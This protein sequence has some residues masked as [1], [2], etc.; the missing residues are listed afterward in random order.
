MKAK[1]LLLLLGGV[2]S[3]D[4]H[5]CGSGYGYGDSEC[6]RCLI[7][8]V[9]SALAVDRDACGLSLNIG[10]DEAVLL[11]E[12]IADDF[13]FDANVDSEAVLC[14][15]G[16]KVNE[17]V[18]ALLE[19]AGGMKVVVEQCVARRLATAVVDDVEAIGAVVA[20]IFH[21]SGGPRQECSGTHKER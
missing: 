3:V 13:T 21:V 6:G 4:Y 5:R 2:L 1:S 19:S 15:C 7:E 18:L 16:C 10:H 17:P 8:C 20:H 9:S 14:R 11:V 12:L